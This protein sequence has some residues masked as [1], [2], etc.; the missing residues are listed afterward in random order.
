M[1][2]IELTGRVLADIVKDDELNAKDLAALGIGDD[3]VVRINQHG[4]IEVRRPEQW[5]VIGGLLGDFE[6]RVKKRSGLEW[7]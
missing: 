3:T 1:K 6:S 4:D 5:D 2:F 7:V